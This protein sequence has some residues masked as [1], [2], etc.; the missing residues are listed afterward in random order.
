VHEESIPHRRA[1]QSPAQTNSPGDAEP[2]EPV[3]AILETPTTVSHPES[4]DWNDWAIGI[5]TGLGLA[6]ILGCGLL[7]GQQL[8]H[9]G[10]QT[11]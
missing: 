3:A 4:F 5:G 2:I 1:F 7:M 6:L 8:R 11:A 9:R 10:I